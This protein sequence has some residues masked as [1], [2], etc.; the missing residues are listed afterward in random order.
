[1]NEKTALV[2]TLTT[3][4]SQIR[5]SNLFWAIFAATA[6]VYSRGIS[7]SESVGSEWSLLLDGTSVNVETIASTGVLAAGIGAGSL[8]GV[9]YE[10]TGI[11]AA[12]L[13]QVFE[14]QSSRRRQRRNLLKSSDEDDTSSWNVLR[15]LNQTS[16]AEH[17]KKRGSVRQRSVLVDDDEEE[18]KPIDDLEGDMIEYFIYDVFFP[19]LNT[20]VREELVRQLENVI[21][22]PSIVVTFELNIARVQVLIPGKGYSA[23]ENVQLFR[24]GQR[25]RWSGFGKTKRQRHGVG[26]SFAASVA[27]SYSPGDK[28]ASDI[29]DTTERLLAATNI[30]DQVNENFKAYFSNETKIEIDPFTLGSTVLPDT[31]PIGVTSLT[32]AITVAITFGTRVG[33]LI[34]AGA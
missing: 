30:I 10:L 18:S 32:F 5:F 20:S 4:L 3:S 27:A 24:A 33:V 9:G 28:L 12:A 2:T 11:G 34:A 23:L 25:N 1:M 16:F 29:Q 22:D 13:N 19:N 21:V 8:F 14:E 26:Q 17:M 31:E 6:Q 7:K 15:T